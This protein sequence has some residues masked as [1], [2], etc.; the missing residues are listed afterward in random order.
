MFQMWSCGSLLFNGHSLLSIV[1]TTHTVHLQFHS[2]LNHGEGTWIINGP[3]K[4]VTAIFS[5]FKMSVLDPTLIPI[6]IFLPPFPMISDSI[7]L[8]KYLNCVLRGKLTLMFHDTNIHLI[9]N[10]NDMFLWISFRVISMMIIQ[11]LVRYGI[12]YRICMCQC[13]VVEISILVHSVFVRSEV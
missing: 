8:F 7:A 1:L 9:T 12:F 10:P 4:G 13:Y 3:I 5:R 6:S 11:N 2:I